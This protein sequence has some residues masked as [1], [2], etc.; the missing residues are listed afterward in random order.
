MGDRIL[1]GMAGEKCFNALMKPL[2][3]IHYRIMIYL[4]VT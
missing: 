3:F 2:T 1:G 4:N